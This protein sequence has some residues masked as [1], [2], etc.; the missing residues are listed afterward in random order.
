MK[1]D[2]R[3]E[4]VT[5]TDENEHICHC[6]KNQGLSVRV[7]VKFKHSEK[8]F[9]ELHKVGWIVNLLFR[10]RN[11]SFGILYHQ[12]L[13]SAYY[14]YQLH[15][16]LSLEMNANIIRVSTTNASYSIDVNEYL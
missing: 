15:S 14:Y 11:K 1:T 6:Q 7:I 2:R 4:F 9:Y 16:F 12:Y 13:C 3:S 10:L 8:V 5:L